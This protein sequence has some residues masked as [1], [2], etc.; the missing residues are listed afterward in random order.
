[1]KETTKKKLGKWYYAIEEFWNSNEF[2]ETN[3][4][5]AFEYA[6][7]TIYPSSD[8]ILRPFED[9][10]YDKLRFVVLAKEPYFNGEANGLCF[11][12][13]SVIVPNPL[14]II[15]RTLE[16]QVYDGLN[17][18]WD[19]SLSHWAEQGGLLINA[20]W[21]VRKKSIG[22]HS[23]LWEKTTIKLIDQVQKS[24]NGLVW[25]LWGTE[26]FAQYIN[27]FNHYVINCEDPAYA[28]KQMKVWDNKDCFNKTNEI[29]YNINKEK[30]KW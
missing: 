10:S 9:C 5:L 13:D 2:K 20:A 17:L 4:V 6:T 25:L 19:F 14:E 23:K 12:T 1:M 8:K 16:N 18:D 26:E 3:R 29:I 11:G 28:A 21:T 24:N 15:Y 7:N 22:S 30:I 27:P